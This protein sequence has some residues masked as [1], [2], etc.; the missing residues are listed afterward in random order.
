VKETCH[1]AENPATRRGLHLAFRRVTIFGMDGLQ[2]FDPN[3][4]VTIAWKSLPHWAQAGT[5][6]FITWR[7]TDSLPADAQDRITAERN[8][9]LTRVGLDPHGNWK[10]ELEKLPPADRGRAQWELFTAWIANSMPVP[11]HVS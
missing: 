3:Q 9:L 4:D 2:F 11:A 10:G 1:V 7:T 6:C 8:T 5:V